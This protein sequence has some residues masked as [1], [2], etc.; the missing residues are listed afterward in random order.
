M[1][2]LGTSSGVAFAQIMGDFGEL[3]GLSCVIAMFV[4]ELVWGVLAILAAKRVK[5]GNPEMV[6]KG[7]VLGLV[8]GIRAESI[9]HNRRDSGVHVEA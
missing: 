6:H 9:H 4:W 5:T 7:A 3:A 8:A 2:L 1:L